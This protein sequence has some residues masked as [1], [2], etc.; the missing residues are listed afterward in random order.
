MP[1]TD[2][3]TRK[4][5]ARAKRAW[6]LSQQGLEYSAI[7][8]KMFEEGV[9]ARSKNEKPSLSAVGAWISLAEKQLKPRA[10]HRKSEEVQEEQ[11]AKDV[12]EAVSAI[13]VTD[14]SPMAKVKAL[15]RL[16]G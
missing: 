1:I 5:L 9:T 3:P 16:L 2:N 14:L 4:T 12:L 6:E 7:A 10:R 15:R 8:E 13:L 11:E